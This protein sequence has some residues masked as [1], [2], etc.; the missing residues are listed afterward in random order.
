M[1]SLLVKEVLKPAL[2][3]VDAIMSKFG[4]GKKE[5]QKFLNSKFKREQVKGGAKVAAV[6][7]GLWAASNFMKAKLGVYPVG[8]SGSGSKTSSKYSRKGNPDN[9]P[10]TYGVSK[11]TPKPKSKGIGT[12]QGKVNRGGGP[13]LKYKKASSNLTSKKKPVSKPTP[14]PKS[15]RTVGGYRLTEKQ[16]LKYLD[17]GK[18]YL[19]KIKNTLKKVSGKE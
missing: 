19:D 3:T 6:G 15:Y 10:M 13:R 14:K 11:P 4:V 17:Q 7:T 9:L 16:Y 8:A 18:D 12:D 5:A 1:S 2:R